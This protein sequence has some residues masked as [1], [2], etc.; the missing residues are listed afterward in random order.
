M[1][2]FALILIAAAALASWLP[3]LMRDS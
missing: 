2:V 3:Q 1:I